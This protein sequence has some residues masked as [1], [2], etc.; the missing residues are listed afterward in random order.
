MIVAVAKEYRALTVAG[1]RPFGLTDNG[2][3]P[4]PGDV[5]LAAARAGDADWPAIEHLTEAPVVLAVFVE[6]GLLAA[7]DAEL[8]RHGVVAGASIYPFCRD[9]LLSAR[10][11]GLGGVMTTF[12]VRRE[13]EVR[14]LFGAPDDYAVAAVIALGR[15][16]H[17][18][19]RLTRRAVEDFATVDEFGGRPL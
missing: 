11:D 3:W 8:D 12:A 18:P 9:I 1:Q 5:D 13:P 10:V 16:V 6:L 4:G 19:S 2:R 14:A 7:M 15:P 17:Q